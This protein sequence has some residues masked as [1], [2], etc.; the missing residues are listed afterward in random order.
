ML[1]ILALGNDKQ[2]E[3]EAREIKRDKRQERNLHK[4]WPQ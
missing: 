2:K 4:Y 3:Q 1:I